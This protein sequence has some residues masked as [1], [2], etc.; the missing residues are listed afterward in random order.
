VLPSSRSYSFHLIIIHD[1]D[2][3]ITAKGR[4]QAE[5]EITV[6]NKM[7]YQKKSEILSTCITKTPSGQSTSD[8]APKQG[9]NITISITP[10][11]HFP[12][13]RVLPPPKIPS[14]YK[15]LFPPRS[16]AVDCATSTAA[17]P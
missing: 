17:Q 11:L 2:H 16:K 8:L 10:T 7:E 3:N 4:R 1:T 13:F 6:R 15:A 14:S 9:D 5:N 12:A